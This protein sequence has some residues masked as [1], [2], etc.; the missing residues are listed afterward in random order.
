MLKAWCRKHKLIIINNGNIFN[1]NRLRIK[2]HIIIAHESFR[3]NYFHINN[4]ILDPLATGKKTHKYST[5]LTFI[6]IINAIAVKAKVCFKVY[7]YEI[8]H[9]KTLWWRIA[10]SHN[11]LINGYLIWKIAQKW[12]IDFRWNKISY[13]NSIF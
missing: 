10:S 6:I 4:S 9:E 8:D 1:M 3:N 11:A 7:V 12:N 2:V 5:S 13:I